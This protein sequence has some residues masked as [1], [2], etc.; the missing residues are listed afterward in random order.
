[1]KYDR[2]AKVIMRLELRT[3]ANER[4]I[5]RNV[6]HLEDA[7]S[8]KQSMTLNIKENPSGTYPT[9]MPK[10][11]RLRQS[12]D[13]CHDLHLWKALTQIFVLDMSSSRSCSSATQHWPQHFT[14]SD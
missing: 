6:A 11:A 3:L 8:K 1:V 10:R 13:R 7:L 5:V 2:Q 14:A 4:I 9:N 12:D